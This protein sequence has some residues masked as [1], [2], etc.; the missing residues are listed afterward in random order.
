MKVVERSLK[1][2]CKNVTQAT[3]ICYY[4]KE[5][6]VK[7]VTVYH[8]D[9]HSQHELIFVFH[10]ER[11][12]R[13]KGHVIQTRPANI[14]EGRLGC[15]ACHR[16]QLEPFLWDLGREHRW[17]WNAVERSYAVWAAKNKVNPTASCDDDGL[18]IPETVKD[19]S[20]LTPAQLPSHIERPLP[21]DEL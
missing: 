9:D 5:R 6:A 17:S 10:P 13:L 1:R 14:W 2:E 21:D 7:T 20:H 8:C 11:C 12:G 15:M 16:R 18:G 19:F 4:F 3:L